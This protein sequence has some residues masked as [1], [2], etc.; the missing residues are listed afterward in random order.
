MLSFLDGTDDFSF[1]RIDR[2]KLSKVYKNFVNKN[3]NASGPFC[4]LHCGLFSSMQ[5]EG[6]DGFLDL[7]TYG[8]ISTNL[9]PENLRKLASFLTP[10]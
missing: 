7:L 10:E 5:N 8:F 3:L 1:S 2:R 9:T 4:F 6:A